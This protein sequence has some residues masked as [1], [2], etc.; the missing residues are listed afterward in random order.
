MEVASI[1]SNELDN[2]TK[3]IKDT[4]DSLKKA[5]IVKNNYTISE[6]DKNKII[7]YIDKV[8]KTNNDFKNIQELSTSLNNVDTELKENKDKIKILTENNNALELKVN[9]LTNNI[10]KKNKEIKELKKENSHLQE[11]VDY[12]KDLFNKLLNFFKDKMFDNNKERE[13][14]FK[15]SK[16][17]YNEDIFD[18]NEFNSIEDDYNWNKEQDSKDKD[19]FEL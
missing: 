11:I 2:S 12:F 5:P 16:D 6:N 15:V 1:K 8:N 14:Y 7:N 18:D 3:E 17:L 19:D 4:I 13:M 10:E 9:T